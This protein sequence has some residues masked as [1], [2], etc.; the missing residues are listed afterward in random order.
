MKKKKMIFWIALFALS[1]CAGFFLFG[2]QGIYYPY[3]ELRRKNEEIREGYRVIDSL[4]REI[5]RLTGDTAYIERIAREKF[6][7]ARPD[8]KIFKFIEKGRP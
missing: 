6:G 1:V 7:M 5:R 2:R 4:Q 3:V 8:E